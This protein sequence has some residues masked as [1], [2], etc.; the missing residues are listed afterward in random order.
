MCFNVRSC[1]DNATSYC[2]AKTVVVEAEV[3]LYLAFYCGKE[4]AWR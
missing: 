4:E 1:K 2:E 3:R